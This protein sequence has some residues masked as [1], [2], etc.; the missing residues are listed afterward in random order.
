MKN[1]KNMKKQPKDHS[2]KLS[3]L[4]PVYNVSAYLSLCLDSI[5]NQSFSDFECILIND[6]STDFSLSILKSYVKQDPRFRLISHKNSGYGASLNKGIKL[7]KGEYIGIVEPDDFIHRDMYKKLLAHKNDIVKCGFMNFYG[8]VRRATPARIFHEV[9]KK[10]PA[11]GIKIDPTKNHKIFLV[12]PTVWSAIYKKELLEKNHIEFLET[13]G[14][15]YQ[16]VGFQFKAFTSAKDIYCLEKPLYYYRRDNLASSVKS[17]KKVDAIKVEF[18]SVDDFIKTKQQFDT[19]ASACRFRSYNWNLNRLKLK[20]ALIFAK[21]AKRDF[22]SK[23]FNPN[24]FIRE[25]HARSH[26]LKFSTQFPVLYVW[27][28]PL[29]KVKNYL[30]SRLY[31]VFH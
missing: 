16:D 1:I 12:D 20:N 29:F 4:V 11:N 19:I 13:A 18:D 26:E 31:K 30:K 10:V 14:A 7:A 23:K 15:S 22:D 6:G 25:K 3:I 17:D 5:M 8:Q 21:T 27:L 9:R 28:R 24:Y 2:P